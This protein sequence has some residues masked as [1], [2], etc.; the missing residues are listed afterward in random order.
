MKTAKDVK[1][2]LVPGTR[3]LCVENTYRP[4]LNGTTRVVVSAGVT[5]WQWRLEDATEIQ[6]GSW[7]PGIR[8]L[9]A[10]TFSMP[11]RRADHTLTLRFM[12]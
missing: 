2:R 7:E 10:D 5:V 8:I 11:L 6:G 9:D 3:L 12:P 1:S 4:Q